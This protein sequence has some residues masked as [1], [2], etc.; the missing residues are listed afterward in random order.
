MLLERSLT[1]PNR[2]TFAGRCPFSCWFRP[3]HPQQRT[4]P[5][6]RL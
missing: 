6:P 1:P 2:R 4:F 5:R 3:L